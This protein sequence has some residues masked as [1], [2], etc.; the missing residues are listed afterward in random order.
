[1]LRDQAS[2]VAARFSKRAYVLASPGRIYGMERG[3]PDS[4][5]LE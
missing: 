3:K 5:T 1:M 4:P 2:G